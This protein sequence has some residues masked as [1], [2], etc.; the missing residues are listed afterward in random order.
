MAICV[1]KIRRHKNIAHNCRRLCDR[2]RVLMTLLKGISSAKHKTCI[3]SKEICAFW[4][5]L[6]RVQVVENAQLIE[7][8]HAFSDNQMFWFWSFS[9]N[10]ENGQ[11]WPWSRS[12][13]TSTAIKLPPTVHKL[14][15]SGLIILSCIIWVD[16]YESLT[17]NISKLRSTTWATTRLGMNNR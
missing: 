5:K 11:P 3:F 12:I 17:A 10:L 8:A 15:I 1:W 2:S 9:R 6:W 16:N 14:G 7:L 13:T 4:S